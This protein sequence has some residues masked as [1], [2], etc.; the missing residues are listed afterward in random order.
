MPKGKSVAVG[1][2][3]LVEAREK[4]SR[5]LYTCQEFAGH[6]YTCFCY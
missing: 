5:S 6:L 1:S 3:F 4:K 2:W